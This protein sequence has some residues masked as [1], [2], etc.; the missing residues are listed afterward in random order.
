MKK[1]LGL[2]G[3][4]RL[5]KKEAASFWGG[6]ERFCCGFHK[7][8]VGKAIWADNQR[9]INTEKGTTKHGALGRRRL[10]ASLQLA[11]S[12]T[13]GTLPS[14]NMEPDVSRA[15][16]L[17][18]FP[19]QGTLS[20][21]IVIGRRVAQLLGCLSGKFTSSAPIRVALSKAWLVL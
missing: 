3:W 9:F 19:F 4:T 1:E 2:P 10:A 20:G 8:F 14:I 6:S 15:P 11:R 12:G 16:G 5:G 13:C 17:D 7:P 18:H 21:S